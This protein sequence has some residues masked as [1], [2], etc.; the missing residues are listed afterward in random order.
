MS[1][2]I[3][4]RH[5][6]APRNRPNTFNTAEPN[7]VRSI[8]GRLVILA[9]G[10]NVFVSESV[11]VFHSVKDFVV[12]GVGIEVRVGVAIRVIACFARVRAS[13]ID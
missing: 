10:R 2:E 7:E 1:I 9:V 5:A 13:L 3:H 4:E 8:T 6:V 12:V 11:I